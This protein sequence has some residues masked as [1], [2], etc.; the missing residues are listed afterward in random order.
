MCVE[1]NPEEEEKASSVKTARS[2]SQ[3]STHADSLNADSLHWSAISRTSESSPDSQ[4]CSDS[5]ESFADE[6]EDDLPGW[7]EAKVGNPHCCLEAN[8]MLFHDDQKTSF[9]F[10]LNTQW[11]ERSATEEKDSCGGECS[12]EENELPCDSFAHLMNLLAQID[13]DE[14]NDEGGNSVQDVEV[15]DDPV[16]LASTPE[17]MAMPPLSPTS[18][19]AVLFRLKAE[20]D[21]RVKMATPPTS[22]APMVPEPQLPPPP[23]R[24]PT[25]VALPSVQLEKLLPPP[26]RATQ[27]TVPARKHQTNRSG[28]DHHRASSGQAPKLPFNAH[29]RVTFNPTE[30]MQLPLQAGE[31][32]V[33]YDYHASGWC[34]CRSVARPHQGSGWVPS[35]VVGPPGMDTRSQ[36]AMPG[37]SAPPLAPA[38]APVPRCAEAFVTSAPATLPYRQAETFP[39][40][41]SCLPLAPVASPRFPSPPPGVDAPPCEPPFPK[42]PCVP[43]PPSQTVVEVRHSFKSTGPSFISLAP[44][45]LVEIFRQDK[46]GWAY[47]RKANST[48]KVQGWFPAWVCEH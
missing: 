20:I 17:K 10:L 34:H 43:P 35:W 15:R 22:L 24:A 11:R 28:G 9:E 26:Q 12:V 33:I 31:P 48:D 38:M 16:A 4:E 41:R 6:M 18:V 47:G 37:V 14:G 23:A 5:Q 7:S 32:I 45:D 40:P 30:T 39:A 2:A 19:A 3:S 1:A 25:E 42:M 13:E 44:H 29:A 46:S 27:R 21:R 36:V 8:P